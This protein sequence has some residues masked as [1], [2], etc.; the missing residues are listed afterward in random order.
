[1]SN[2]EYGQ[3]VDVVRAFVSREFDHEALHALAVALGAS[4][5][6]W[7][8]EFPEDEADVVDPDFDDIE[9]A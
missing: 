5:A 8:I 9:Y 2:G 6:Y 4:V 3:K 1:M 7:E